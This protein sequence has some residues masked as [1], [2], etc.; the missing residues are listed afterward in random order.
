MNGLTDATSQE[1]E[2]LDNK[3]T[4]E[5]KQRKYQTD[6]L[7]NMS[8]YNRL[9]LENLESRICILEEEAQK[10]YPQHGKK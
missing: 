7:N 1:L 2:K 5:S 8:E 4:Q 10:Y 6:K 3:V 9:V